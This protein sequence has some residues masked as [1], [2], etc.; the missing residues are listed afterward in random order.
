MK[1]EHHSVSGCNLFCAD[2]GLYTLER[3]LQ[4]R[5]PVG[6]SAHR[7]SAVEAG[8]TLGLLEDAKT[9][10][11]IEHA[12][13]T[14]DRLAA[15]SADPRKEYQ[16]DNLIADMV[17]NALDELRPYGRPSSVQGLVEW[18][19]DGLTYPF[20]GYYDF[21]W[22]DHGI[23][24][25]LKTTEKLHQKIQLPHA[26]QVALYSS[27]LSDNIDTRV[28]YVTPRK[29][30]TYQLENKREHLAA[31]VQIAKRVEAFLELSDDP[32][33]FVSITAPNFDSFYWNNP[34]A[35]QSGYETWGF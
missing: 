5:Q 1:I 31:L 35:R 30:A 23:L 20:I 24:I 25:D 6:C 18:H 2:L 19:P 28:T 4:Q 8:V 11:C 7:G 10:D 15:M 33:F 12:L 29:V 34:A 21:F 22:E 17:K 13:G 32:G 14:Y 9:E 27:V 3:I 16:R 26:R